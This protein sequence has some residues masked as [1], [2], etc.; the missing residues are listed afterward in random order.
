MP[1]I[2]VPVSPP[3]KFGHRNHKQ[4]EKDLGV[5]TRSLFSIETHQTYKSKFLKILTNIV[6]FSKG[7]NRNDEARNDSSDVQKGE[8]ALA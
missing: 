7:S 6:F 2:L 1:A 8:K 4:H 3:K 5:A